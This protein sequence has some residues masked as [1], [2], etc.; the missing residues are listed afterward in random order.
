MKYFSPFKTKDIISLIISVTIG[1]FWILI[2]Q[3][4][5]NESSQRFIAFSV[6]LILLLWSQFK[7]NKPLNIWHY[8]NTLMSILVVFVIIC[9]IIMHV[10][11]LHD[12]I[13]ILPHSVLLWMIAG[14]SPYVS[15]LIYRI[16]S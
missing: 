12:F 4:F 9:S 5:L 6:L 14:I 16:T 3:V 10:I 1:I 13:E 15:G 11:I 2:D 8:A 7:I